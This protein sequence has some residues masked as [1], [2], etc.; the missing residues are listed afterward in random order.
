MLL[1]PDDLYWHHGKELT[2]RLQTFY[3]KVFYINK[4][5]GLIN[6][7]LVA[8]YCMRKEEDLR[9]GA[10]FYG[11]IVL[12]PPKTA[13]FHTKKQRMTVKKTAPEGA[14]ISK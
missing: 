8:Y 5:D 2:D 9:R 1:P 6:V 4:T 3:K 7:I 13:T 11:G 14:V 10:I 12:V